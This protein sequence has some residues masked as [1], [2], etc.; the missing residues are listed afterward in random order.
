MIK[1]DLHDNL[2]EKLENFREQGK[3]ISELNPIL[4]LADDICEQLYQKKIVHEDIGLLITQ[5]G[6]QL[7]DNQIS[8]LRIKTG[9]EKDVEKVLV[10]GLTI[11]NLKE[12]LYAIAIYHD[13]NSNNQFDTFFSIPTFKAWFVVEFLYAS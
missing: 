3:N 2:Y 5:M 4:A 9:A 12:S 13:E 6:S 11:S 10:D 8:E 7:W 1:K